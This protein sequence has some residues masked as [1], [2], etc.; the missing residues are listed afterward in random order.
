MAATK[1]PLLPVETYL[2]TIHGY[3]VAIQCPDAERHVSMS[4]ML[5][6][7]QYLPIISRQ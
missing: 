5:G 1:R 7:Q 4:C 3:I 2:A 6:E